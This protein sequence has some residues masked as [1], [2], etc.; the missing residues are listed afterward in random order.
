[1]FFFVSSF[2]W[3]AS[4]TLF[5]AQELQR[6]GAAPGAEPGFAIVAL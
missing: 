1:M 5:A 2:L 6:R 3:P 4:W